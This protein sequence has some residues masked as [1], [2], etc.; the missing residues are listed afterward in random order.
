MRYINGRLCDNEG[1]PYSKQQ[2]RDYFPEQCI[3][4]NGRIVHVSEVDLSY[5]EGMEIRFVRPEW[6]DKEDTQGIVTGA[7]ALV[8]FS[9][10]EKG[11]LERY[12]ICGNGPL[13][14]LADKNDTKWEDYFTSLVK[15]IR[16]IEEGYIDFQVYSSHDPSAEMCAFAQ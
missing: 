16:M 8:G 2:L 1:K 12:L 9:V 6:S 10:Q 13:S 4:D 11:N 3:P 14:P 5:L 15:I 7:D